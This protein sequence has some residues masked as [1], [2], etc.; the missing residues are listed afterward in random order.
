SCRPLSFFSKDRTGA[1]KVPRVYHSGHYAA[2]LGARLFSPSFRTISM[3]SQLRTIVT[4]PEM[5][6]RS[7]EA[8]L[9]EWSNIPPDEKEMK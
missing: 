6:N 3:G 1:W 4:C 5:E 7:S 8:Q 9:G 2:V